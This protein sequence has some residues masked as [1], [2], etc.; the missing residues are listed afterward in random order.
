MGRRKR[1]KRFKIL[2][3]LFLAFFLI[4]N[5]VSVRIMTV[6]AAAAHKVDTKVFYN[7]VEAES[8]FNS[9]AY[10]SQKAIGLG[11]VKPSTAKYIFPNY[12]PGMLFFPPANLHISAKYYRYLFDKYSGNHSLSLAAYNW[13]EGN[14]DRKLHEEG[15]N[16]SPDAD[17]R[18]VFR[19]VPETYHYIYRILDKY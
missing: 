18:E 2:L 9:F 10:S 8:S 7:L 13:G 12:V 14:V 1:K 17:Y 15:I 4:Y 6:T 5:P 11:Q 16:I 19:N 3:W